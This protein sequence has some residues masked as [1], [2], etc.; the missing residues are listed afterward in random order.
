MNG[1]R[2]ATSKETTQ[3]NAR[4]LKKLSGGLEGLSPPNAIRIRRHARR[5]R[6]LLCKASLRCFPPGRSEK[7]RGKQRKFRKRTPQADFFNM[8]KAPVYTGALMLP[9]VECS[10]QKYPTAHTIQCLLLLPSGP[11]KVHTLALHEFHPS[12]HSTVLF[13]TIVRQNAT[14]FLQFYIARRITR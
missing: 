4:L 7:P 12:S 10:G 13:Y 9:S 3:I 2:A 14:L 6:A 8:Q 1:L 5:I 11:D